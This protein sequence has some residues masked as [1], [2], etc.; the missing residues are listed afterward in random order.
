MKLPLLPR[1]NFAPLACTAL[2][3]F[4]GVSPARAQEKKSA[5]P[6]KPAAKAAAGQ[7]LFDGKT[8]NGWAVTDFAGHGEVKAEN[9]ELM[10]DSGLAL[11]GVTFTNPTPKMDY[12]VTLEGKKL[13][14]NDFFC[15][16]TFP[17]GTNSCTFVLGGWGGAVTGLSS[18]DG[19]DASE[20]E[21]TKFMKFDKDKW[22]AVRVKVAKKRIEA[23]VDGEKLVDLD[24]ADKRIEMR[25][26]EIELNVPFGLATYQTA[27][28]FRNLRLQPLAAAGAKE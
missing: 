2:L 11:S 21:T 1:W 6:A 18:V 12:E 27:A 4:A 16:L 26:G 19:A 20:N 22:Y 13:S 28:A 3:V 7:S 24:T 17:Y 8:L 25:P 15:G 10:I 23:W 9:G 14:G 5:A